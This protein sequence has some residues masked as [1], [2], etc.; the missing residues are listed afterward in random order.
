[1]KVL[2]TAVLAM[3]IIV[4]VLAV[5]IAATNGSLPDTRTAIIG[6]G[7]IMLVL[8]VAIGALRRGPRGIRFFR[9][10]RG[11]RKTAR[12]ARPPRR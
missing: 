1:M 12:S 10:L 5:P 3:E 11:R 7:A 6:A 8:I 4:M 2:G 9:M